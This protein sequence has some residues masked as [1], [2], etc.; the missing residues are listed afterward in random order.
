MAN[1]HTRRHALTRHRS[2]IVH[3]DGQQITRS[4][5]FVIAAWTKHV[6]WAQSNL[7]SRAW[8]RRGAVTFLAPFNT[9]NVLTSGLAVADTRFDSHAGGVWIWRAGKKSAACSLFIAASK[10]VVT[11]LFHGR[12]WHKVGVVRTMFPIVEIVQF[13]PKTN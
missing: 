2:G 7:N 10:W 4:S 12:R 5:K 3:V 6:A 1:I 11:N 13:S 9:S 8:Q